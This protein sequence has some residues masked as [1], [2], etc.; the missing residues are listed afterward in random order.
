[1]FV[2]EVAD[3]GYV[4]AHVFLG[5]VRWKGVC[6]LECSALLLFRKFLPAFSMATPLVRSAPTLGFSQLRS[7]V[8]GGRVGHLS[9]TEPGHTRM[10]N[11]NKKMLKTTLCC[12]LPLPAPM[13]SSLPLVGLQRRRKASQIDGYPQAEEH[14]DPHVLRQHP[15]FCLLLHRCRAVLR[16]AVPAALRLG[17]EPCLRP[18]AHGEGD[19]Q[20]GPPRS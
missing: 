1:M 4:A 16:A 2:G 19:H 11:R 14:L 18:V 3:H 6:A 12:R 15:V 9:C 20:L 5:V 13:F 7:A 10:K 17:G 8:K